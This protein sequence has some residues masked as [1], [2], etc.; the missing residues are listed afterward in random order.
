MR[1]ALEV[2]QQHHLATFL[3]Q[4]R[5]SVEQPVTLIRANGLGGW[6]RAGRVELDVLQRH[7]ASCTYVPQMVSRAVANDLSKPGPE[8][9]RI[10][11]VVDPL[12]GQHERVLTDVVRREFVPRDGERGCPATSQI[13]LGED[14][15]GRAAA[16]PDLDY[17]VGIGVICAAH[18]SRHARAGKC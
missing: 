17:E 5:Q 2:V 10:T 18:P 8:T 11:A 12:D 3:G 1:P 15:G 16:T 6:G 13:P 7:A 9:R 4:L 14:P